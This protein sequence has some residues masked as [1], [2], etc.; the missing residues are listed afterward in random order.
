MGQYYKVVIL[1]DEKIDGKE[2]IRVWFN[3]SDYGN[4]MK[5]ME[6]SYVGNKFVGHIESLIR[7]EGIL[8]KSRIVWAGDYADAEY[9]PDHIGDNDANL[10]NLASDDRIMNNEINQEYKDKP[11]RYIVN[12]T[13]KQYTDKDAEHFHPLPL[14]TAEGNGRGGGD[15]RGLNEDKIG[16]WARDVISIEK[17]APE[18]YEEL[19]IT[20]GLIN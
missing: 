4:G 1:A 16:I 2:Y 11:Y 6:H 14:L 10:Y 7:P 5:L 18:G 20:F 19:E 3:P 8:Y 17:A 12:H 9:D 15:Y 13:K